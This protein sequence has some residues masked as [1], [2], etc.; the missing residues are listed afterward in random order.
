MLTIQQ[1]QMR[2]GDL[3]NL[4]N[5]GEGSYLEFKRSLSSAHKIAREMCAFANSDGGLILVGVDDNRSLVGLDNY[6]EEQFYLEQAAFDLCIPELPLHLEIFPIGQRDIL[7]VNIESFPKKPVR[8]HEKGTRRAYVRRKDESVAASREEAAL[9]KLKYSEKGSTFIF[10]PMEQILFRY[11]KQYHR[12]S[13]SEYAQLADIPRKKASDILV[14]LASAGVID[15]IVSSSG[16]F[17][18]KSPSN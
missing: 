18:S 12:I 11:I 6:H 8:V 1:A 16:E 15:F 2:L 7:I 17:F 13:V 3:K 10:G 4:V 9:L 5:T 14:Q